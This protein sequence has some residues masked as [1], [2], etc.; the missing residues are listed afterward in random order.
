MLHMLSV[1]RRDG[2]AAQVTREHVYLQNNRVKLR[3]QISPQ[4]S[5]QIQGT[6]I[7]EDLSK[8]I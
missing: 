6:T 5:L 8:K 4:I 7:F 1:T 2:K 3:R